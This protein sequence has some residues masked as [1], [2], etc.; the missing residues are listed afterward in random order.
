MIY[1]KQDRDRDGNWGYIV[2]IMGTIMCCACLGGNTLVGVSFLFLFFFLFL[3]IGRRGNGKRKRML[4]FVMVTLGKRAPQR[5][6]PVNRLNS[7]Q[8]YENSNP[9][10]L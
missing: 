4:H 2:W 8:I 3:T 5:S 10:R 9:I 1:L 6:R 7:D